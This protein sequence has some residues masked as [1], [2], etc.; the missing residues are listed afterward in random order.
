MSQKQLYGS[1]IAIGFLYVAIKIIFVLA[2]YLHLG[3]IWHGLVPAVL[4]TA[5]GV[6]AMRGDKPAQRSRW[7]SVLVI[8]PILVLVTTPPFMYWKQRE[9]W[10]A[11]GRLPVLIIYECMALLQIAIAVGLKGKQE[12]MR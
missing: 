9:L 1:Y 3:A 10:L 12:G 7:Y 5:A 11:E 6:L 2:G 8:L 4:T